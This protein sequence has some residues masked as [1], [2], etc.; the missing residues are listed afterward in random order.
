MRLS[1]RRRDTL[2]IMDMTPMIDIVFLLLIFFMTVSQVSEINKIQ[3]S[4]PKLEGSDDQRPAAELI[5]DRTL[6]AEILEAP[7]ARTFLVHHADQQRVVHRHRGQRR[8]TQMHAPPVFH[9]GAPDRQHVRI[10]VTGPP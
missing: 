6:S 10:G 3:L 7:A 4:L 5:V 8:L 9:R 2:A 1:K